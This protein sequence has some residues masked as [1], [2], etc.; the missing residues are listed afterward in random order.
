MLAQRPTRPRANPDEGQV[1]VDCAFSGTRGYD[2][3]TSVR[4][5]WLLICFAGVVA[6]GKGL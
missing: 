3:L 1:H 5:L 4:S 2:G 6:L